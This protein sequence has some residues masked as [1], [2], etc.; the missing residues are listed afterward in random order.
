MLTFEI[1]MNQD[2]NGLVSPT[3][4]VAETNSNESLPIILPEQMSKEY[5]VKLTEKLVEILKENYTSVS[6]IREAMYG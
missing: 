1:S 5:G 2:E 4:L 6:E 3:V